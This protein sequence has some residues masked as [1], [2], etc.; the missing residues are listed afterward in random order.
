M[1]SPSH[2]DREYDLPHLPLSNSCTNGRAGISKIND[3]KLIRSLVDPSEVMTTRCPKN[4]S[5]LTSA[6]AN[7]YLLSF[8]NISHMPRWLSD[9]LCMVASGSGIRERRLH[10]NSEEK[11]ISGGRAIVVN[12]IGD[13]ANRADIIDRSVIVKLEIPKVRRPEKL[14][15]REGVGLWDAFEARKPSILGSLYDIVC[16][17]MKIHSKGQCLPQGNPRMVDFAVL[18]N[19]LEVVMGW[20]QGT[21]DR[22]YGDNRAQADEIAIE[23]SPIMGLLNTAFLDRTD[24][25]IGSATD[26]KEKILAYGGEK[27]ALDKLQ[28]MPASEVGSSLSM[29]SQNLSAQGWKIVQLK[30]SGKGRKWSIKSPYYVKEG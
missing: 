18:G 5:D 7:S 1:G 6:V 12:G 11:I 4:P 17:T 29:L 8:D 9:E 14:Q 22:V 2:L 15:T 3:L 19:A 21:F 24:E 23:N 10:T 26:F 30:R 28:A 20:E 25:W 13:F 16:K 27:Y